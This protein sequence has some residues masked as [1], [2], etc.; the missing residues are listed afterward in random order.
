M[1]GRQSGQEKLRGRLPSSPVPPSEPRGLF[2]P[3][4]SQ[5]CPRVPVSAEEGVASSLFMHWPGPEGTE[6]QDAGDCLSQPQPSPSPG[7]SSAGRSPPVPPWLYCYTGNLAARERA[8]HAEP[9][10]ACRGKWRRGR[11][12]VAPRCPGRQGRE[13]GAERGLRWE[14]GWGWGKGQGGGGK[15]AAGGWSAPGSSARLLPLT[16]HWR[17]SSTGRIP[18]EGEGRRR[19]TLHW[20]VGGEQAEAPSADSGVDAAISCVT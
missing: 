2:L 15:G 11:R 14:V 9:M 8:Q 7:G 5:V 3:G 20:R 1:T 4:D 16:P 13:W 17:G 10:R 6:S 12:A 19:A 18:R